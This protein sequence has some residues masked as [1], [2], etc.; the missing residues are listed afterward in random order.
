MSASV[1]QSLVW[2]SSQVCWQGSL[3]GCEAGGIIQ[4]NPK[5]SLRPPEFSLDVQ[6]VQPG[7]LAAIQSNPKVSFRPPE[8]SL[9]VQPGLFAGQS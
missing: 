4:S 8:F 9:D 2:V 3:E 6:I 7:L 1:P 5:V